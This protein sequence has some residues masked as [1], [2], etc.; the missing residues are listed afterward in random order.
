MKR[1]GLKNSE[2]AVSEVVDFIIILSVMLLAVSVI[3]VYGFPLIEHMQERGHTENLKQGFTVVTAN[4]NKIVFGKAPSQSVELKMY[5]GSLAVTGSSTINVTSYVWNPSIPG[6]EQ[7]IFERQMRMIETDY[8]ETSICYENTGT[9]AK[10]PTGNSVMVSKPQFSF[11]GD[12]LIVPVSMIAGSDS[13]G[14][15]GLVSIISNGGER[16]T[17]SYQNVSRVDITIIS[18][19]YQ[20]WG[21]YLEDTMGMTTSFDDAN[22][23]VHAQR[24]Y[25]D[26]IDV[27][28][29]YSPMTVI[30]E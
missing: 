17:Y 24:L 15:S 25:S 4:L 19:H 16:W 6:I 14:G 2:S 27:H 28:V 26:N 1:T 29:I 23:T 12:T 9:W 8:E 21:S 10:Y 30:I 13:I 3:A 20:G 7:H 5:G 11:N 22:S 18:K